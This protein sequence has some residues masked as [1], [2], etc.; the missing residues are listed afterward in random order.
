MVGNTIIYNIEKLLLITKS[1]HGGQAKQFYQKSTKLSIRKL[2]RLVG[3]EEEV[4]EAYLVGL[5]EDDSLCAFHAT[6]VNIMSKD[7]TN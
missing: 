1:L 6:C 7:P 2:Q 3:K 5:F 4:S